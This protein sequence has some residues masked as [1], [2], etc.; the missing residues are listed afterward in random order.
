MYKHMDL[1]VPFCFVNIPN[2]INL[3]NSVGPIEELYSRLEVAELDAILL[4][5]I[6]E[7]S[8][9]EQST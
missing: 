7:S 1:R 5:F 9:V 4:S 8:I 3:F 2:Q 6:M